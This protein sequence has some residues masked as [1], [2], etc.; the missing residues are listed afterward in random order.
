VAS[1]WTSKRQIHPNE[2]RRTRNCSWPIFLNWM[3]RICYA[4]S[5]IKGEPC[6]D[7]KFLQCHRLGENVQAS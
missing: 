1:H 6:W 2:Y 3:L 7:M 5:W 4:F